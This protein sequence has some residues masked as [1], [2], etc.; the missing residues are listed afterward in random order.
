MTNL[1]LAGTN[2]VLTRELRV[3]LRNMRTFMLLA[4]YVAVLGAIV[5]S[6]FPS[7]APLTVP[8]AEFLSEQSSTSRGRELLWQ[9]CW[10]QA[11]L[12]WVL[13][14]SLATGALS[15]ERERHTLEPLLLS[16]LTP[17][18]IVWGKA[19]GVLS[20]IFLLLLSTLPL[21]SLCFLLG[22]VAPGEVLAAY[23]ILLGLSLFFTSIGLYC[24]AKWPNSLQ[25]TLWCYVLVGLGTMVVFLL[26][27]PG[28]IVSGLA[29]IGWGLYALWNWAKNLSGN[30]ARSIG[31]WGKGLLS[32]AFVALCAVG[33][34]ALVTDANTR[35][36][37]L[38]GVFIAPYLFFVARFVLQGAAQELSKKIE[39]ARPR[40]EWAN[41]VKDEWQ[42]AIAP[43]PVVYVPSPTGQYTYTPL[44]PTPA[45]PTS[46]TPAVTSAMASATTAPAAPA[47]FGNSPYASRNAA[48][49]KPEKVTYGVTPFLADNLNPILAKDLRHGL[50][51]RGD[52][53]FRYGYVVTIATEVLLLI[54]LLMSASASAMA[55][56]SVFIG[57]AKFQ[58]MVLMIACAW[59]GARAIAPEREKQVLP[60][61]LST[62]LPP[63]TIVGGKMLSVLVYSFYV[64]ILGVPLTLFLPMLG[65]IP[66]SM[67]LSYIGIELIFAAV[68]ASWG[69]FCSMQG[70]TVRRALAWAMGGIVILLLSSGLTRAMTGALLMGTGGSYSSFGSAIK[71]A[72]MLSPQHILDL[73]LGRMT[74]AGTQGLYSQSSVWSMLTAGPT[75]M[76]VLL[77]LLFFALLAAALLVATAR[78][79]K[80]YT[81]TL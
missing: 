2:P 31:F 48:T 24:A 63:M 33:L 1:L 19:A 26:V 38:S 52:V 72:Q 64:F 45:T 18:Q 29:L 56:Q 49:A 8:N 27:G 71:L 73:T 14:P 34:W 54:Y 47:P 44:T 21:T 55:E 69:I 59:L 41:D 15:Q 62:P 43:P 17:M 12:V 50:A 40:R 66:W 11:L 25:A 9:F 60:Q 68:A 4:I 5:L 65:I 58:L 20:L 74:I 75:L 81:Q 51:G 70:V 39:P 7:D 13:V 3:V 32:L 61:L 77:M 79:F 16:P 28:A 37:V 67:S 6:Q 80:R 22:G 57:W 53:F 46:A 42:R 10:A 35:A 78:S 23:G 76:A 36:I 30:Q